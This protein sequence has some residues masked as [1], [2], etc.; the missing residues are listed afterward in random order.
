MAVQAGLRSQVDTRTLHPQ[1]GFLIQELDQQFGHDGVV[2][3]L[4]QVSPVFAVGTGDF[5]ERVGLGQGLRGNLLEALLHFDLLGWKEPKRKARITP[6]RVE[7]QA[8]RPGVDGQKLRLA[9]W[10]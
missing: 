2:D 1:I 4:G 6:V 9:P 5:R 7:K 8:S 10:G 3:V